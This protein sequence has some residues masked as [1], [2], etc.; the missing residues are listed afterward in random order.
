MLIYFNGC[1]R[2]QLSYEIV[3]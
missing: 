1:L 2:L 3:V